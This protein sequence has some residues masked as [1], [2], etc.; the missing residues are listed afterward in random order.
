MLDVKNIISGKSYKQAVSAL[1][2][3][4]SIL[5]LPTFETLLLKVSRNGFT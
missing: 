1:Q 4:R 3:F 5:Y 2:M